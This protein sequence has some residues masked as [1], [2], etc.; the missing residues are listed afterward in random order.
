LQRTPRFSFK[1]N[2]SFKN[3]NVVSI[4]DFEDPFMRMLSV[5]RFVFT[6]DAKIVVA[7]IPFYSEPLPLIVPFYPPFLLE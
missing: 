1:E 6:K 5:L 4:N 7:S 2:P 3:A